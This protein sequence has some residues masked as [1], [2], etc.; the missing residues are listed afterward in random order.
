M[1]KRLIVCAE[2]DS[3]HVSQVIVQVG[4]FLDYQIP[5]VFITEPYRNEVVSDLVVVKGTASDNND[6]EKVEVRVLPNDWERANGFENWAWAWNTSEDLNGR[7]TI[8]ARSFDGYNYSVIY[9][10]EVEVTND[11]ANRRPT[12]SLKSNFDE[13]YVNDKLIFSGNTSS[14]DSQI[15]KYHFNFGDS[16]ETDWITDSW[17]EYYYE[18][19]GEYTVSLQVEDDE[20]VKSSSSDTIIVKVI[21]KPVNNNPIAVINSP[22]TGS[23]YESDK[24]IQFSSQGSMDPDGDELLFTW[25]SSLDGELYTTPSFFAESFLTDG[26]HLITLTVSDSNGGFDSVSVQITVILIT[27]ST[28]SPI[29]PAFN[30]VSVLLVLT[31]ISFI[32]SKSN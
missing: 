11:G 4:D 29:L 10:V 1:L 21:E 26:V 9:S 16:K 3:N 7:Y 14:D 13:V 22:Q 12:A 18:E 2:D 15:V 30:F 20:G 5:M 23:N 6:V 31:F 32:R 28:E 17:I 8:E 27:E 25:S 19:P 24:I